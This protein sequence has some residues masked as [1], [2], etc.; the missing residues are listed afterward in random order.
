MRDRHHLADR[1]KRVLLI[2]TDPAS[3]LD[4]MLGIAL[5]DALM[6]VSGATGLSALNIN[7]GAHQG[8]VRCSPGIL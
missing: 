1:G 6:L 5:S 2:S 8:R 3:N 4:E 7:A